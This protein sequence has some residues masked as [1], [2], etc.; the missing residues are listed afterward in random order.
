LNFIKHYTARVVTGHSTSSNKI[1]EA[2]NTDSEI[3]ISPRT[4]RWHVA[5]LGLPLMKPSLPE[6]VDT[7]KKTPE[8]HRSISIGK[9]NIAL[10]HH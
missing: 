1:A 10:K 7:L 6:M 8:S 9:S 5:K 2:V 4:L 3:Q